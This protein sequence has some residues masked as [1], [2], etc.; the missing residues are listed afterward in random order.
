MARDTSAYR[1]DGVRWPSP[2]EVIGAV[3]YNSAML[4]IPRDIL[5][6]A[7]ERG[8]RVHAWC[9]DYLEDRPRAPESDIAPQCSA[10]LDWMAEVEPEIVAVEAVVK[11]AALRVVGQA[12]IIAKV[13][14]RLAVV[15]I[16]TSAKVY[17]SHEIQTALYAMAV[18]E[19]RE[20]SDELPEVY[21]LRLGKNGK[22]H[23][24]QRGAPRD[25]EV[26]RQAAAVCWDLIDSG[27]FD[28]D[29]ERE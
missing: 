29:A 18:A 25:F 9:E 26:G 20:D 23:F 17:R 22:H 27:L 3:G 1:I 21:L 24:D 8:T 10:F 28:P 2:S 19:E 5:N 7:A 4:E 6:A 13:N 12:D 14:G 15:D 16:K 11:C